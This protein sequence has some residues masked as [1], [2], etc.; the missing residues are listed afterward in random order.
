MSVCPHCGEPLDEDAAAC[1]HCGS[2]DETGWKPDA[3]YYSV[4]LPDDDLEAPGYSEPQGRPRTPGSHPPAY[5]EWRWERALG[6]LLVVAAAALF[7]W[8]GSRTY[9]ALVAPFALLL[10]I[11]LLVFWRWMQVRQG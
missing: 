6:M 7:L 4:E 9:Q 3:D 5:P 10:G 2:D 11:C 8:V 1:P